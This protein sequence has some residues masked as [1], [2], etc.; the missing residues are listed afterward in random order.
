MNSE[1]AKLIYDFNGDQIKA[2][3]VYKIRKAL[4]PTGFEYYV[5]YYFE[6]VLRFK[7][8]IPSKTYSADGGIDVKWVKINENGVKE[9][10]IVQCKKHSSS[11]FGINSIRSFLGGIFHILYDYPTTRAYFIT[12]SVYSDPALLFWEQ[13]GISLMDY[14]YI[15]TMYEKY[16]LSDFKRDVEKEMPSKY[17]AIFNKWMV[18]TETKMQSQLFS[19][20]EDELLKTLKDIRYTIMKKTHTYESS[21]ITDT[22]IL[23]YLSRKRPHNLDSLKASL[24]EADFSKEDI[25]NTLVYADEYIKGL[26]FYSD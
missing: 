13:E 11:T 5:K 9:Y 17:N 7:M 18:S 15:A 23:E 12:T 16:S 25:N 10:C 26:S 14:R 19:S 22:S 20:I 24:Y 1:Q 8:I 3:N 2:F 21:K 4:S 6:K